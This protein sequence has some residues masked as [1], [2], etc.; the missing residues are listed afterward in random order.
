MTHQ[1]KQWLL[2]YLTPYVAL[3][4]VTFGSAFFLIPL[5]GTAGIYSGLFSA[6]PYFTLEFKLKILAGCMAS[7]AAF[8][9]G[10][11]RR[12]ALSGKIVNAIGTYLWCIVGGI[13]F[14]PQ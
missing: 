2:V 10:F 12:D 6:A 7:F 11:R 5:A 4:V 13:G 3:G 8:A 14:G 9:Y 1:T